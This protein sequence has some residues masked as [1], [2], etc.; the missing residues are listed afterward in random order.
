[1]SMYF[2]DPGKIELQNIGFH[3]SVFRIRI[4][5]DPF[6]FGLP[7]LGC[8]NI[9]GNSHKIIQNYQGWGAGVGAGCF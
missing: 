3:Y 9:V 2:Q 1:M 5:M 7:D 4:R 8:K 6:H